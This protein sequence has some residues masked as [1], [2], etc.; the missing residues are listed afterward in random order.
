[1]GSDG[2]LTTLEIEFASGESSEVEFDDV[3]VAGLRRD[4]L[5]AGA[6][7]VEQRHATAPEGSRAIEG[8]I[9]ALIVQAA[10]GMVAV[11]VS[12]IR[13]LLKR[14]PARRRVS[15]RIGGDELV[16]DGATTEDQERLVAAFLARHSAAVE[17]P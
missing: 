14:S 6:V 9:A 15:V 10:P 7:S 12:A 1:V 16:L 2:L 13:N 5:E 17:S 11:V 4:V 3:W 8:V